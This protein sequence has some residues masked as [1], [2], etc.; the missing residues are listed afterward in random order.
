MKCSRCHSSCSE[1][2]DLC[3]ECYL[4][5]R[6][7]KERE[8]LPVTYP[9]ISYEHLLLKLGVDI[10][11]LFD[12]ELKELGE[13]TAVFELTEAN[14]GVVIEPQEAELLF[15]LALE[16]IED[17]E[18]ES[19]YVEPVSMATGRAIDA[20]SLEKELEE[21]KER[22]TA[23]VFGLKKSTGT[24]RSKTSSGVEEVD[25]VQEKLEHYRL[26]A[27]RTGRFKLIKGF[28]IDLSVCLLLSFLFTTLF[29]VLNDFDILK[30]G[31]AG[32]MPATIELIAIASLNTCIFLVSLIAYPL[33]SLIFYD[34]TMG[35]RMAK[36]QILRE[37]GEI[38]D[39]P[40]MVVRSFALPVSLVLF[41][42]ITV[43]FGKRSLHDLAAGTVTF[44]TE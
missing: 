36:L 1:L 8:G 38:L 24:S 44:S 28:L 12:A 9:G 22:I 10:C 23:P 35:S 43:A 26:L 11:S 7:M 37:D 17:P 16:A 27:A 19:K 14:F 32:H 13:A 39:I 40:R 20:A 29:V 6:P 42:Y 4:D 30:A 5:F 31:L 25:P 15:D 3:P 2:R 41:S 34:S 21:V 33:I 18:A